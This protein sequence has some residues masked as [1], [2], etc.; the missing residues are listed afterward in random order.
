MVVDVLAIILGI[1]FS[2]RRMDVRKR[3]ADQFPQVPAEQFEIWKARA[4]AAYQLGA[5]SSFAKIFVDYGFRY[6]AGRTELAWT[7]VQLGG[8]LI[9]FSWLG[10]LV[11]SWLQSRSARRLAEQLG[12]D[13]SA[14][15]PR[16][17][18]T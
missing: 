16:E 15:P 10:L 6:L 18:A 5:V 12:L 13:L 2:V 4:S 17:D 14:P 8:A 7:W 3:Q 9:F 11:W 1:L